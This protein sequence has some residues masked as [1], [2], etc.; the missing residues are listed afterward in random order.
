MRALA[1][2]KNQHEILYIH[3]GREERGTPERFL[4]LELGIA[5]RT[6][7]LGFIDDPLQYLQVADAYVM[8][9]LYEGFG[10]AA[11]EAMAAGAP[12]LLADVPGLRDIKRFS[13]A[14][15]W[16]LPTAEA[17]SAG[18]KRIAT[19]TREQ[20]MQLGLRGNSDIQGHFGVV[21]GVKAYAAF[22]QSSKRDLRC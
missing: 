18:L 5:E 12:I 22:Y 11:L 19:M 6:R 1:M 20:R 15:V 4:A 14:P 3:I 2:L 7:F 8:P 17:I 16:V 13:D 21:R 10:I 9:S